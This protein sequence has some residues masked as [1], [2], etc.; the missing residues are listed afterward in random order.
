MTDFNGTLSSFLKHNRWD[1]IGQS[2]SIHRPDHHDNGQGTHDN[3]VERECTSSGT[4]GVFSA[5]RIVIFWMGVKIEPKIT[6][7]SQSKL[8]TQDVMFPTEVDVCV[9]LSIS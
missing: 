7:T 4:L 3:D 6:Y 8:G 9:I 5:K 1:G 2:T